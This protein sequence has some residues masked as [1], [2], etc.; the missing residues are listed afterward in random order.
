MNLNDTNEWK[1][2]E[3]V[4]E[5]NIEKGVKYDRTKTEVVTDDMMYGDIVKDLIDEIDRENPE[6]A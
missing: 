4:E 1:D 6:L 5:E 2:H 3:E